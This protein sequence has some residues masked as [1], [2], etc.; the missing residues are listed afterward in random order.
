[1]VD[2]VVVTFSG[3]EALYAVGSLLRDAW[4]WAELSEKYAKMGYAGISVAHRMDAEIIM[5]AREKIRLAL[6][7]A[8]GRAVE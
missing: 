1:M 7:K 3:V 4:D 5:R 6:E 2:E 8:E